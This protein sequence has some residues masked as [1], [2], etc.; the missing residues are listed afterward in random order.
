VSVFGGQVREAS[1]E[2]LLG[3]RTAYRT[4]AS[5]SAKRA[6][7][8]SVIWASR[9]LRA[10]LLSLMPVDVYRDVAGYKV[11]APKPAVLDTP[12]EYAPGQVMPIEEWIYSTQTS[13]D[14]TGNIVG[15]IRKTDGFGLPAEIEPIDSDCVTIRIKGGRI[16]EYRV[17]GE[18][19]KTE[20]IWHERQFTSA[21]NPVGLSPIAN[22]AR[23]LTV[24]LSAQEFAQTWFESGGVPSAILRNTEKVI[25]PETARNAK[26]KFTEAVQAGEPFITGKDWEYSAIAAKAAEAEFIA[27]MQYT[28]ADLCRF[29]GVPADLVD[30]VVQGGSAITYA[31]MLQRNLQFLTVSLGG[32]VKRRE[33]A[34]SRL[35]PGGRYV[36]LNRNAILAMDPKTRAEVFKLR[37]DSRSITPDQI[38]ALEDEQPFNEAD[39][40][41][42]ERLVI[43]ARTPNQPQTAGS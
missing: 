40:A 7:T 8:H 19:V 14:T 34:F 12:F 5:V 29:M 22:A 1:V 4:G 39:Y 18:L 10:D 21:G 17:S 41:Q 27:M 6:L 26:T 43:P 3:V 42:L 13:L 31:N 38:R 36:K 32:A 2:G 9:H 15:V 20:H 35:T 28:D 23:S 30:V 16:V 24:G 25:S 37:I 11:Q 33:R